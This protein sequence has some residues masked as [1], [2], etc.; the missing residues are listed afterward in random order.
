MSRNINLS[1]GN[2]ERLIPQVT[3]ITVEIP[4]TLPHQKNVLLDIGIII[5]GLIRSRAFAKLSV[6][7]PKCHPKHNASAV[8]PTVKELCTIL[9]L[10][11]ASAI[12]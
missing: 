7:F 8:K 5:I 6:Y 3:P 10:G 12:E 2:D 11:G 4:V 1:Y 9:R